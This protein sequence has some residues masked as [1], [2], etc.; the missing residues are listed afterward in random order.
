MSEQE[1]VTYIRSRLAE[2]GTGTFID[3]KF[4]LADLEQKFPHVT[5]DQVIKHLRHEAA[6]IG[7]NAL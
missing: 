2:G 1:L 3:T 7:I 6:K 5:R 4:W